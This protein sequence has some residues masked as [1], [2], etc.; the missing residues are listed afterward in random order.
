MTKRP[1]ILDLMIQGYSEVQ[2]LEIFAEWRASQLAAGRQVNPSA[3]AS[4]DDP[5]H[6]DR[7]PARKALLH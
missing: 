2:M 5:S 1:D 6:A 4:V 7:R 3:K